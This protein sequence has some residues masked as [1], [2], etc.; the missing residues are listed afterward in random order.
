MARQKFEEASKQ[1][2]AAL[3]A[4]TGPRNRTP[5]EQDYTDRTRCDLAEMQLRTGK[6]KDALAT[7][8]PLLTAKGL[9]QSRHRALGLYY[10]GFASFV[11]GDFISAGRSLLS[12]LEPFSDP[13]YGT[14]TR[15]LLARIHHQDNERQEA[16]AKYQQVI[17]DQNR[18]KMAAVES[19]KQ[20]DNFK[21]DPEEKARLEALA[22]GVL[23]DYVARAYALPGRHAVRGWQVCRRSDPVQGLPDVSADGTARSGGSF[24]RGVCKVQLK[25]FAEVQPTLQPLVDRSPNLLIR[26]SSGSPR[27]RSARSI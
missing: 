10:H 5:T 16:A 11:L 6:P 24:A 15:Y 20:P 8:T 21:N 13:V 3:T 7:V 14:H 1:F 4:F 22:R 9:A 26:H 27:H 18:L 23:P 12:K 17:E 19:L 2:T 25:Q